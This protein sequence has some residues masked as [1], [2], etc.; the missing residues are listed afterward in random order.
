MLL[1]IVSDTH[2]NETRFRR[3]LEL[4]AECDLI[5]HCGDW[6]SSSMVE[7]CRGLPVH[8]VRGNCDFEVDG[9]IKFHE[10][11]LAMTLDGIR[12][13]ACH[14]HDLWLSE[15]LSGG[16][17]VVLSGHTHRSKIE[18]VQ[19]TLHINPGSPA[20]PRN[21][22]SCALCDTEKREGKILLL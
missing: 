4:L 13:G 11:Y 3:V 7:L 8:G 14:G 12:V 2:S 18:W 22:A 16:F 1:G 19:D 17:D 9:P 21:G 6:T 10:P 20:K 15:L 5:I